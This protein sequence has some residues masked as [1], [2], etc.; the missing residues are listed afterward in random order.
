MGPFRDGQAAGLTVPNLR[1]K[2]EEF[3]VQPLGQKRVD[4]YYA[5][6]GTASNSK[7][8]RKLFLYHPTPHVPFKRI[9][10]RR[11]DSQ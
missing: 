10:I 11:K 6:G 5:A 2:T 9:I 8:R 4:D 7:G 3:G 1:E